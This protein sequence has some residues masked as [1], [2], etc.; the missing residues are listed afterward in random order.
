MDLISPGSQGPGFPPDS[1]PVS[2]CFTSSTGQPLPTDIACADRHRQPRGILDVLGGVDVHVVSGAVT[3]TRPPARPRTKTRQRRAGARTPNGCSRGGSGPP[4]PR[5]HRTAAPRRQQGT[6]LVSSGWLTDG[7]LPVLDHVWHSQ[8]LESNP[9][10]ARTRPVG[11][12]CRKSPRP[13]E[14]LACARRPPPWPWPGP[15]TR[16]ACGG[17]DALV[18][19][20][21]LFAAVQL[22]VGRDG[23]PVGSGPAGPPGSRE[24]LTVEG[25]SVAGSRLG[26]DKRNPLWRAGLGQGQ[27]AVLPA[28]GRAGAGIGLFAVAGLQPS[29]AACSGSGY[30]RILSA[31]LTQESSYRSTHIE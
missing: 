26:Q 13:S 27:F 20:Q 24:R 21:S 9:V 12:L 3:R 17:E 7:Q 29:V 19:L 28:E 23:L 1:L 22:L 8:V 6:E 15:P 30:A 11:A 25:S 5:R 2:F 4:Q 18:A 16:A 31:V 14:T 10:E